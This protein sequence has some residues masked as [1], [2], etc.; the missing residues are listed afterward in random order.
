MVRAK[1]PSE[2]LVEY[3]QEHTSVVLVGHGIFNMSIAKKLKKW[4]GG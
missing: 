4:V 2:L 1:K 3:A